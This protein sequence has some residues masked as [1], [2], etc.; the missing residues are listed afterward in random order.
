MLMKMPCCLLIYMARGDVAK[1]IE[2]SQARQPHRIFCRAG[3]DL[4]QAVPC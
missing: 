1:P 3:G 2:E 4:T